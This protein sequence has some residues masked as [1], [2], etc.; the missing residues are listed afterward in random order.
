MFS[1][2]DYVENWFILEYPQWFSMA[3]LVTFMIF[4]YR[5][6]LEH[7]LHTLMFNVLMWAFY[8]VNIMEMIVGLGK[9]YL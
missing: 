1:R 5:G 7:L 3:W 8:F 9:N 2:D 6:R 4:K